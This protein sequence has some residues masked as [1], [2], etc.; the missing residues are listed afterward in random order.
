MITIP[1]HDL[2]VLPGVTF[3]FKKEFFSEVS[4]NHFPEVGEEVLFLMMKT[5]KDRSEL[6][7]EDFYPIGVIGK[8]SGIDKEKNVGIDVYSRIQISN[9]KKQLE[10]RKASRKN[11]KKAVDDKFEELNEL[12]NP[13]SSDNQE[14]KWA[15]FTVEYDLLSMDEDLDEEERSSRFETVREAVLQFISGFPWAIMVRNLVKHW[16]TLEEMVASISQFLDCSNEEKYEIIAEG[17]RSKLFD[18]LEKVMYQ[19]MEIAKVGEEVA[20]KQNDKHESMYREMAL[21]RQMEILQKQLDDMH[22]ETKSDEKRFEEKIQESGMNEVARREAE[23]VLNRLKQEGESGHEY[24]MLYDYLEF[25][26]SL[27]WK[28]EEFKEF[29]LKE[30]KAVL[31]EEHYG[32]DKVKSRIIQ[33]IAV[34]SLTKK[35]SGSIILLVGAPG[36]GKTSIGKSVA[37]ALH[38]EYVRV[39]LGGI[40]D[41]AEIRGHR[42]TYVGAMPGRIMEGIRRSGVSN[43]VVVLD[44]V[45]KLVKEMHGD[46]SSALLEVLD[47]EQNN[48]FTDHYM[49]VPYDLSDVLFICTANTVDTIP[50][51]LLNRMEVIEFQGYTESE[52][53]QIAKKHLLPR[54]LQESGLKKSNLKLSDTVLHKIIADYTMEAGVRGLRKRMDTLCRATAVKLLTE[55][56]KSIT[57]KATDLREMLD[58]KP[59]RHDSVK[60]KKAPGVVTGLAWTQTGGDVLFIETMLTPGK[61]EVQITGQLGDVMKESV[62]VATTLVKS[63]FPDKAEVFAKNNIHIHVPEGAVSKDG[64][65]AGITLTTALSSLVNNK[66]VAGTYAM[67]GEISLQ[68]KVMPIGGLPEKL[69]AAVRSGVKTVFIPADNEEDLKEVAEEVKSKLQIIPVKRVNE[70]LEEVG[71]L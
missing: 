5:G 42:R 32:L 10:N 54:A 57:V 22:P 3:Y 41:E 7:E 39:S 12:Q 25:V 18:L 61:G 35:Q 24:G 51:P 26:T 11:A 6:E 49:N 71:I 30:A 4:G 40:R 44:E 66:V 37:K 17:K 65:S 2:V 31:D 29:D 13:E 69:M 48:T 45:D 34:M 27:S 64:P 50:G 59:V 19:T 67:T 63:L 38:R 43:P 68:G 21:K 16:E 70:V 53:M 23:K 14:D 58:R 47:P 55:D 62:Q 28:K 1:F 9:I 15:R 60:E 46:P 36:T 56:A 20:K 52:K 33:Q 8:V